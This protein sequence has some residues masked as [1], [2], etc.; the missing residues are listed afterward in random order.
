MVIEYPACNKPCIYKIQDQKGRFYIG[1]TNCFQKRKM[2]HIN[3]LL[4]N[5][6]GNRF[7]QN[8]V[9]KHGVES[10][11][12]SIVEVV[13]TQSD[14]VYREQF[15]INRL[16]PSLNIKAI[17]NTREARRSIKKR[18]NQE[19]IICRKTHPDLSLAEIGEIFGITKQRTYQI[20][21]RYGDGK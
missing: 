5:R 1:S 10:L 17:A 14:L 3:D 21:K 2:A 11:T 4:A 6:H 12:F 16:S 20:L 7:I 18:R 19:L 8:I 13:K 9:R 15:Y